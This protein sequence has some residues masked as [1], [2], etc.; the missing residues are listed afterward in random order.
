MV[1][2]IAT[3]G[4]S[5]SA[6]RGERAGVRWAIVRDWPE[7]QR[8]DR[9]NR[10]GAHGEDVAHD[11]ADA[12]GRALKRLDRARMVVRLDLEGDGQAIADVND[13]GV[14]LTRADKDFLRPGREGFKQRARVF[15]AAMLAP[16]HREDA[17]L[18]VARF[19]AQQIK[20]FLILVRREVVLSNQFGGDRGFGHGQILQAASATVLFSS[21]AMML[22]RI[23]LPSSL[24]SNGSQ[25]RSGCGIRPATLRRSLQMPAMFESEP[26]GFAVSVRLPFA[27]QYCHK[28]WLFAL[29][30]ARV[31][32]S[33]K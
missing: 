26:F 17:Q 25:A 14:F 24:P 21:A 16:H 2:P 3:N 6:R 4:F 5:L 15:I 9:T 12:G 32:S 7:A 13:A 33:A 10:P 20:D 11:A 29:S 30:F 8:V 18:G 27:S 28:I 31:S 23:H 22:S 1:R 19:A